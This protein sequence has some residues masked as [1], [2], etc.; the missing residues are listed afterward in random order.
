[1][2]KSFLLAILF[3]IIITVPGF[4][5]AKEDSL[6]LQLNEV[7]AHKNEYVNTRLERIQRLHQQLHSI[8]KSNE[9][10][11]FTILQGLSNEYKTF[12]Y[13]SAFAIP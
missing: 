6:F 3:F 4:S 11:R 12:I 2:D 13:D 9:D 5:K 1:M 8:P 10:A 7:I